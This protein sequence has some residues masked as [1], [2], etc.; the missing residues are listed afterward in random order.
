MTL[1]IDRRCHRRMC[2]DPPPLLPILRSRMDLRRRVPAATSAKVKS[3]REL[4][5]DG[6][7]LAPQCYIPK[8]ADWSLDT[9][10]I[11]R[12]AAHA[13]R[14][15]L[16]LIWCSTARTKHHHASRVSH[17]IY[18]TGRARETDSSNDLFHES[19]AHPKPS[20]P[21]PLPGSPYVITP[22]GPGAPSV[23][24]PDK[25]DMLSGSVLRLLAYDNL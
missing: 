7:A 19:E 11:T 22:S 21:G 1:R 12:P 24:K 10:Q 2:S 5:N 8:P 13:R 25:P 3:S 15:G 23:Y 16:S 9:L 6:R 17:P 14:P 18:S 4:T 20:Q